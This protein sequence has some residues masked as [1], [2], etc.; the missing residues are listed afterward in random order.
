[1]IKSTRIKVDSLPA[2]PEGIPTIVAVP[3]GDGELLIGEEANGAEE[4]SYLK[5]ANWKMLLGKS[6]AELEVEKASNSDLAKLLRKTTLDEVTLSYFKAMLGQTLGNEPEIQ[7]KPQTIIGVPPSV[8]QDQVRWRQNYKRRIERVFG[9]LGYPKPRFW[10]EPFAVFSVSSELSGDSRSWNTTERSSRR[11]RR[12]D[13]KRLP[14]PNNPAR[15]ACTGWRQSCS[16]WG[17]IHRSGWC[18]FRRKYRQGTRLRGIGK[19]SC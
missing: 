19:P 14:D 17:K 5:L 10:P 2:C 9:E 16:S 1:M 18:D 13:H 12:S 3:A 6:M 7:E 11:C 8:S 15:Q 4:T